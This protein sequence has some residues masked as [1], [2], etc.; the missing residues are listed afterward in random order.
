MGKSFAVK[1]LSAIAV[2]VVLL[3]HLS[4]VAAGMLLCIG[5]GTDPDCCRKPNDFQESR[6]DESKQLL[7]GSDCSCCITI[8]AVS[9]AAG[10]RSHKASIGLTFGAEFVRNVASPASARV[11]KAALGDAGGTRLSSLRTVVLLI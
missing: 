3:G 6:L 5:D 11:P 4:P 2:A 10:A 7:D 9:S 8:D 1:T